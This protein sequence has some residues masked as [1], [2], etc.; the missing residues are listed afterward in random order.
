MLYGEK[1]DDAGNATVF[2]SWKA[3][4]KK[5]L[6]GQLLP[7]TL[8]LKEAPLSTGLPPHLLSSHPVMLSFGKEILAAT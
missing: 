5:S 3:S 4:Q 8:C 7:H 2:L 6:G 1:E